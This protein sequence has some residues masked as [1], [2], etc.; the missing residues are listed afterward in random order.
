MFPVFAL[1]LPVVGGLL[2]L[3]SHLVFLFRL[4]ATQPDLFHSYWQVAFRFA[5]THSRSHL[6]SQQ[7]FARITDRPALRL[8]HFDVL[9]FRLFVDSLVLAALGFALPRLLAL[10]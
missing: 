3:G 6:L 10:R 7:V 8:H 5:S 9:C 1:L 2:A 4:R